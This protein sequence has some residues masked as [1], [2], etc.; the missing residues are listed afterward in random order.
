MPEPELSPAVSLAWQ[1][2]AGEGLR[3]G[4]VFIE[5]EHLFLGA[6]SLDKALTSDHSLSPESEA[7]AQREW[8]SFSAV[9][10]SCGCNPV[11]LRREMRSRLGKSN[12]AASEARISRSSLSH[13]IFSRAAEIA[14]LH[15]SSSVG[16]LHLCSAL[17]EEKAASLAMLLDAAG[18]EREHLHSAITAQLDSSS[19]SL[20]ETNHGVITNSPVA[21]PPQRHKFFEGPSVTESLDATVA[22]SRSEIA[23]NADRRL[24]VFYELPWQYS[25]SGD[26]DGLLQ[27]LLEG[28]ISAIPAAQRGN[29][30]VLDHR[31]GELL[32]K[33]HLPTGSP[34]V[35]VTSVQEAMDKREAFIWR[36]TENLT[37]SQ[38]EYGAISGIYA[39]LIWN[40][41]AFGA[42]TLDNYESGQ[43]TP[44]DL[45][46]AVAVAHQAAMAVANRQLTDDLRR[47][48]DLLERLMTSFSPKVRSLLLEKASHGRL[49][50]G[51]ERSEV[52]IL[53][54]D[55]R[56]FTQ[57]SRSMD[58]EAIVDMLN[59]Y[60]SGLS[61]AIFRNDGTI[62]KFMGDAILAV[63]GSPEPDAQHPAKAVTA[64]MEMQTA[65]RDI[66]RVRSL[67][68][69]PI[70][71][72]GIG[73][74]CGEVLHGFIGATERMEFTV[75]GDTVNRASRYCSG[76][77]AGQVL[78]ST[79]LH[80]R[81]WKLVDAESSQ[82]PTKH[83][84]DFATFIVKRMKTTARIP[85][86]RGAEYQR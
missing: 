6:C 55:I 47:K 2:A 62:D 60:F 4:S 77:K 74:H 53:C 81:V 13:Q 68:N 67:R 19:S 64:A 30:L 58:T 31:T 72:I 41:A 8:E 42:L 84:G 17:L 23:A 21:P 37:I 14:N 16:L 52:T 78:I 32:L 85:D 22:V 80:Q 9:L 28:L 40:G 65:M 38:Q 27:K 70:C 61:E 26:I 48:N 7:S 50:P 24:A 36:R 49:R 5:P 33:A 20:E 11:V 18:V 39:P 34:A 15:R 63:F 45:R 76:A 56:G 69:Q 3:C 83:E 73:V 44:E 25:S 57:M 75:I 71:E 54:S 51:G 82:I 86:A 43:F 59:E 12:T 35:S 46:L 66:N 10:H 79:E 1:I 29:V